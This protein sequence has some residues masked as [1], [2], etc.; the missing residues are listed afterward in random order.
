LKGKK[1]DKENKSKKKAGLE[2]GTEERGFKVYKGGCGG[3]AV[4]RKKRREVSRKYGGESKEKILRQTRKSLYHLAQ[5]RQFNAQKF[6]RWL[7]KK[8]GGLEDKRKREVALHWISRR[9]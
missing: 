4:P 3:V 8:R 5:Y 7:K 2:S 9:E 6:N 1:R